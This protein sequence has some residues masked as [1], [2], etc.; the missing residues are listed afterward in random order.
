MT[1]DEH[2][3][4]RPIILRSWVK[5]GQ[6]QPQRKPKC[7]NAKMRHVFNH[8]PTAISGSYDLSQTMG[9]DGEYLGCPGVKICDFGHF[10]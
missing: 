8:P 6:F 4:F 7:Q 5:F 2:L 9:V 1:K 10:L 3:G